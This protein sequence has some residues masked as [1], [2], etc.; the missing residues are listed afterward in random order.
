MDNKKLSAEVKAFRKMIQGILDA[1]NVN[2]PIKEQSNLLL[3]K[4]LD[5]LE[6]GKDE[7]SL[8]QTDTLH[9]NIPSTDRNLEYLTTLFT[10][11]PCKDQ[12]LPSTT[13]DEQIFKKLDRCLIKE[14]IKKQ[15][16]EK[17]KKK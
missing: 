3:Q 17:F 8:K 16:P 7:E 4:I 10:K 14:L 2:F 11:T 5:V 1:N 13:I 9:N 6:K 15:N 12:V